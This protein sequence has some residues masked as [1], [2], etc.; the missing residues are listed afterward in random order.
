MSEEKQT[1]ADLI[2]LLLTKHPE[3]HQAIEEWIDRYRLQRAKNGRYVGLNELDRK[4]EKYIGFD[5][6]Y[7]VE[8]GANDGISQSNTF[9]YETHR[10]WR[11]VLIEPVLH[12]YFKCIANRAVETKV[13]CNACVSFDYKDPFVELFYSNLMSVSTGLSS[14]VNEPKAHA[15]I[16]RQ[17]LKGSEHPVGFGAKAAPLSELLQLAESPRIIDF[18]SLDVEGAEREVLA[19]IDHDRYRFRYMCIESRNRPLL[20]EFLSQYNYFLIEQLSEHD[21]LYADR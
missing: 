12:N 14:D 17:F 9:Y 3:Y 4:L 2:T 7:F 1:I 5:S 18:L 16:G 10:R 8:L 15:D 21:Y 13:F 19:G 20:D 6:G 11:G